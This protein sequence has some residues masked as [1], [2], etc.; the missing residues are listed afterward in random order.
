MDDLETSSLSKHKEAVKSWWNSEHTK[1]KWHGQTY[2]SDFDTH[3]HYWVRQQ[4]T[5]DF[6]SPL[7]I[8]DG[9]SIHLTRQS[10]IS[11]IGHI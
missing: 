10:W 11:I 8:N 2:K 9:T 3:L 7:T 6:L 1:Q 5:L 4:K